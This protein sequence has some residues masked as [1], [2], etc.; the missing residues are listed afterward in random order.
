[1][2]MGDPATD[3]WVADDLSSGVAELLQQTAINGDGSSKPT[4][5]L[6][7]SGIGS[8]AIGTNGG[9]PTFAKIVDVMKEVEVDDAILREDSTYYLTNTKVK[10]KMMTTL[11]DSAVTNALMIYDNPYDLL[12]GQKF[13]SQIQSEQPDKGNVIWGLLR[14]L[15]YGDFSNLIINLFGGTDVIVDPYSQSNAA[16]T[17]IVIYQD[18]DIGVRH[19]KSFAAVQ[20]LTT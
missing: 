15:L 8:V 17:R 12:V 11:R 18:N 3:Q 5:I 10:A 19:A 1:M 9:A 2:M 4:G 7:T 16:V 6:Q 20:D 14:D 13:G